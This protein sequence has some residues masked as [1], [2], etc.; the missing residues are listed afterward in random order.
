MR[1]LQQIAA[2]V[3]MNLYSL[4]QRLGTSLVTVIGI[5]GVVGVLICILAMAVGFARTVAGTGRPDRVIV[6]SDGALSESLSSIPREAAL[7]IING[8]GVKKDAGGRPIAAAE[9]L[10]QIQRPRGGSANLTNV[11]LRGVGATE[12]LL[13][14]EIHIV[15]GRMFRPA[16]HEL[17]VGRN[18]Q[19]EYSGLDVG[20][21]LLFQN[22]DWQVVGIFDTDRGDLHD[23]EIRADN[24]TLLS[25]Y[26]RNW[27]Q[28]VTALLERPESFEQL[29]KALSEDPT[30]HVD[31]HRESE[32]FATQSKSLGTVLKAI[33]YFVGGVMAIGALFAALNAMYTTVSARAIEIATLRAIGFGAAPVVISVLAEALLLS[34]AGAFVGAL[35][36]WVFFDGHTTSMMSGSGAQTQLAFAFAVT[37]ELIVIGIVWALLIGLVGGLVPAIRAAR[38]PVAAALRAAVA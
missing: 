23:A 22:G 33:G 36:A 31:V 34:L 13:R 24:E 15:E 29:K 27:F 20:S 10:A 38:L 6:L 26:Q 1:S 30:L 25:A 21:H 7:N 32:Y 12:S 2:V 3:A 16:V 8:P 17:I 9:A 11:T 28:S 18:A 37:P 35:L 4:P 19:R 14:P 5:A